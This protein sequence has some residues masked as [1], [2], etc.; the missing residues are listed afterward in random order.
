MICTCIIT[1]VV[2]YLLLFIVVVV[3][4]QVRVDVEDSLEG[5]FLETMNRVWSEHQ[6]AMVM[7]RDILM[8]MVCTL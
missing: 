7:I 8:Y 6:T 4:P 5:L 1:I 3:V 2:V